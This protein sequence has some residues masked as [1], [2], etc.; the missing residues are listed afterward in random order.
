MTQEQALVSNL[1]SGNIL[2]RDFYGLFLEQEGSRKGGLTMKQW[3]WIL[4]IF[5]AGCAINP[6][7]RID[8]SNIHK[9]CSIKEVKREI[10][11]FPKTKKVST[12][13]QVVG[14]YHVKQLL[15]HREVLKDNESLLK[16]LLK[17]IGSIIE[18]V[19][20][21]ADGWTV[22][23][24]QDINGKPY[25]FIFDNKN[26][27][28]FWD[29]GDEKVVKYRWKSWILDGYRMSGVLTYKQAEERRA[30][31][32]REC[33]RGSPFQ[34]YWEEILTYK[35]M[36]ADKVDKKEITEEEFKYLKAQ[37]IAE[38][39]EKIQLNS[40][41]RRRGLTRSQAAA[42]AIG[43]MGPGIER[44]FQSFANG[45]YRSDS[46]TYRGRLSSNPYLPDSTSN[47]YGRYGSPF[48]PD[49]INN[50]YGAGS[51][52][53]WDSPNNPYGTGLKIYG[54]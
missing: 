3:I 39:G 27:L 48:S 46:P 33:V 15:K 37:K 43:S 53:R 44:A 19:A 30:K 17:D 42:I 16:K 45:Y 7:P 34:A 12:P 18:D 54:E 25:F 35:I 20:V 10:P 9:G 8:L 1:P 28:I 6:A 40:H 2:Y 47:P 38:V 13:F 51:P 52:Y 22:L 50:P 36:L 21:D 14:Y 29:E 5:F 4:F 31:A 23:L 24:Y 41:S 32:A 11:A 26:K 49:S